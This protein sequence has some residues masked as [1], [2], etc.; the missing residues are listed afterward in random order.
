[1]SRES[2][3]KATEKVE[4]LHGLI[5]KMPGDVGLKRRLDARMES[6]MR[7]TSFSDI[8]EKFWLQAKNRDVE[9]WLA[10]RDINMVMMATSLAP[11]GYLSI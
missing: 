6:L 7:Y 5:K 1:M 4:R 10:R 11:D 2:L 9:S 3:T 8:I